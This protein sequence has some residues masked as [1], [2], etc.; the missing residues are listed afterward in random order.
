M[1]VTVVVNEN[2]DP[3][4]QQERVLDV[5]RR[6]HRANPL[7]VRD[8][9]GMEKQ[10]VNDALGSLVDAGWVKRVNRGLYEFVEDPRED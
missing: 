9:T 10:R 7:R 4:G 3:T 8:V 5:F 1:S 6:E 2:F